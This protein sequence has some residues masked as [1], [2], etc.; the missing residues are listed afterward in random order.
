M[1]KMKIYPA[2]DILDG[3]AVRLL[4]GDYDA[5]TV[6]GDDIIKTARAIADA[7]ADGIH[8]VDLAGAKSGAPTSFDTVCAVKAETGAF[9]E[10]GGGIRTMA[11]VDAYMDAGVD[12]VIIGTKAVNDREFLLAA[13]RKYGSR[14]AV[15]IDARDG[16][17][18][19]DGWLSTSDVD[20]VT[21]CRQLAD[22]G[23]R[24]FIC[25][26]ISRDG[27]MQG[28][29]LEFYRRLCDA[30]DAD[31]I[32]SGGISTV[33]DI[34]RLREIGVS[35]AIIGR[36]YYTGAIKIAEAMRAAEAPL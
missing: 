28:C 27:A 10:V 14:I 3:K 21:L 18:A 36:A 25:T 20:A 26:D 31:I 4:R 19:T 22:C 2:I 34:S 5:R 11:D 8:M 7:G 33:G 24:S 12:R 35:G 23:I 15:G 6:Y 17:A 30:V 1:K 16:M 9:C 32:A 29:N 13:A